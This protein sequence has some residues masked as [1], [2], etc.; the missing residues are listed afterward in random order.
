MLR[1]QNV[2]SSCTSIAVAEDAIAP[3]VC[4]EDEV[5]VNVKAA[6]VQ[7][8]DAQICCGYGRTLR[9][10]LQQIYKQSKSDL[11]VT[12]GR[13]CTGIITDIGNKVHRL[14][15]GDEVWVTVPF[16]SQG[17]MCQTI[18]VPEKWVGRKPKIIGFESAC[19]L[20]YS[21]S[22][23]LS[24]LGEAG[25]EF[26]NASNKRILIQGGC[27]PVGCVLIQLLRHWKAD[28]TTTCYKRAIPVV[29]ALGATD[30][31]IL[32]EPESINETS[33]AEGDSPQKT[34]PSL[35]KQ[36]EVKDELYDII[37]MTNH[38]CDFENKHFSKFLKTDGTI[39]STLPPPLLSDSCG[40]SS[41]FLLSL[42][43]KLRHK[44]LSMLGSSFNFF[45]ETHL[46]YVTLD[47]LAEF[48]EDGY[49]QTVVDKV[50]QPH[51]IEI[52][53]GHI[54]SSRSIGSTII[55]FR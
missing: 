4:G 35:I 47:K 23:A 22:L 14:E 11:P 15:V 8:I 3:N 30:V 43:I 24:A 31:I 50:Y 17:T 53:V 18:S 26:A 38:E 5:L 25:I 2:Q 37:I 32:E 16:W 48:V 20:P 33:F 45:D 7:Y 19:S 34:N 28:I 12:L 36:L 40:G 51:D 44:F 13:D 27:S 9:R 42:Y 41:R 29:K 21:G 46:C 49:L 39:I 6:S 54:Q 10:I 52:A 1:Y 55:T